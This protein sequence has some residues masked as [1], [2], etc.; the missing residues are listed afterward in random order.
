MNPTTWLTSTEAPAGSNM[1]A[2]CIQAMELLTEN[3][4]VDAL[5]AEIRRLTPLV[6]DLVIVHEPEPE[7]EQEPVQTYEEKR[8]A[9]RLKV[10][11]EWNELSKSACSYKKDMPRK[12]NAFVRDLYTHGTWPSPL[13][14]L[15]ALKLGLTTDKRIKHVEAICLVARSMGC[16]FSEFMSKSRREVGEIL[17]PVYYWSHDY[18][19]FGLRKILYK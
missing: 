11:A 17:F 13:P 18:R 4:S 1:R 10:A 15:I 12:V 7:P 2:L 3:M 16:T 14:R 6:R 9:V 5:G 19:A 8:A